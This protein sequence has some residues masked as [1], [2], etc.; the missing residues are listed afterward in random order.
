MPGKLVLHT[1]RTNEIPE[2]GTVR[3][4]A[5]ARGDVD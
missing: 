4:Q 1:V 2:E 5:E 3:E